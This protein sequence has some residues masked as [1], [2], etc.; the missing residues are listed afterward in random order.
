MTHPT[1]PCPPPVFSELF[2]V[3]KSL[4]LTKSKRDSSIS[5]IHCISCHKRDGLDVIP[6]AFFLKREVVRKKILHYHQLYINLSDPIA[7][8]TVTVDTSGGIYDDF[9]RLIYLHSHRETRF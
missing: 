1:V 7:F 6:V 8:M 3:I 5:S 4:L 2:R 9:S